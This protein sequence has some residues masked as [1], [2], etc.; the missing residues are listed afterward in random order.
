VNPATGEVF[1]PLDTKAYENQDPEGNYHA[2]RQA[3]HVQN[4]STEGRK[5]L[6]SPAAQEFVPSSIDFI[7]RGSLVSYDFL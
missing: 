2:P 3:K 7:P 1:F 4:D 6:L 5:P